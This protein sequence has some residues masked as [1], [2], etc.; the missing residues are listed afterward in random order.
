MKLIVKL[1]VTFFG[2]GLLR[3]APGTWGS[4]A[5]LPIGIW[6][7]INAGWPVLLFLSLLIFAIGVWTSSMYVTTTGGKDPSEVVI[8]EVA[9]MWLALVF[10]GPVI[11]Q[12]V[13][14]FVLFRFFDITK[15]WWIGRLEKLPKGWG[16]MSDDMLAGLVAGV[17]ML[18]CQLFVT[19]LG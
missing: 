4:L 1:I 15:L 2:I 17:L 3:P 11:W 16:I 10:V 5:A 9:G 6:V 8:D 12:V 19:S 14:A 13:G 18:V 7:L